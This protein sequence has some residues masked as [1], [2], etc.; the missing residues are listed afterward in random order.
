MLE[1]MKDFFEN[2]IENYDQHMMSNINNSTEFYDFTASML[3]N[4][5]NINIL[6]LGCGTGLELEKYYK[7][8]PQANVTGI[9]LSQK[10]LNE[11]KRKKIFKKTINL[12]VGSYFDITLN[13]EFFDAAV[14]VESLHHYTQ[15]QKINLYK[16]LYR[17]LKLNGFFILTDF[18]ACSVEEETANFKNFEKLK[19]EQN[20]TNTEIYHYD[21]PLTI[22]HEIQALEKSGFSKIEV[23]KSWGA[24]ST[25]KAI[26]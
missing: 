15:T 1:K 11:L 24:T 14:S 12:I 4:K 13:D 6:D 7:L 20:L 8:C 21:T 17:T 23:L 10:M 5:K 2:R 9:D 22:E 19:K 25:I 18:F 26:K 3:P 16:K